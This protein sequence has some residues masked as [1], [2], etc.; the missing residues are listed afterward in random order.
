MD[1]IQ[2]RR[3]L[4]GMQSELPG[5]YSRVE[6]LESSG[7]QYIYTDIPC[8]SGVEV[9]AV[10]SWVSG[11]AHDASIFGGR[12]ATS[13]RVM[14]IH[15][16][17]LRKWT[18]GY[19]NSN[20]NLGSIA[21]GTTYTVQAKATVGE[22]YLKIDGAT[23]YSGSSASEYINNFNM[24]I[25]ACTYKAANNARLFASARVYGMTVTV[26]G[27]K[28]ADFI[29]CIRKSDSKPGMY[30]TVSKTFYTNAGTGEFIVPD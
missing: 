3:Q 7:T 20:T 21:Y 1:L 13:Q 22:Q 15:Q 24:S 27:L 23:V 19:G 14:L 5:A 17:P 8:R 28:A 9:E 2:R 11:G 26:D 12:L 4:M 18:F 16:Y 6:Y 30:D 25:F 10:V 29:P